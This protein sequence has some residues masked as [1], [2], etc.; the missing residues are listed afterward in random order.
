MHALVNFIFLQDNSSDALLEIKPA[1]GG[2]EAGLFAFDL[3]KLYR[4]VAAEKV[5]FWITLNL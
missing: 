2:L 1:A 4:N 3:Y 5:L